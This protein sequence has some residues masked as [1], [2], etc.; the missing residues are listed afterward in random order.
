M[1][2]PAD[3]FDAFW[4]LPPPAALSLLKSTDGGLTQAEAARRLLAQRKTGRHRPAWIGV[5]RLFLRQFSSPLVL[6]L[7]FAVV[8]SSALGQYSDAALI[9]GILF[10]T[11][12]M[13][14]WQEYR[15]SRTVQKLQALVHTRTTV[16]RG[17]NM[18]NIRLEDVVPGD[19][20]L[21]KAGDVVPG[22]C[23]L[24]QGK[25]VHVNESA[26]T[27]ESFPAEKEPCVVPADAAMTDRKNTLFE[28]SSVVSGEATALVVRSGKDTEFGKIAT[29]MGQMDEASA[30]QIGIRHFG[31]LL[32]RMTFVLS[33]GILIF[34]LFFHKPVVESILFSI[35]LA[36]GLAPE[37][38]PAIL[39][40]TLSAGAMRMAK[41]KVIVKKLAAIQ[42]LGA[43]NILCSDKTGTLTVGSAQVHAMAD[44]SNQPSD[45]VRLYAYLNAVFETGFTNPLDEAIRQ[46]PGID[47]AGYVKADEV[48]YDFLRKRLSIVVENAAKHHLMLTK[49]AL[50]NV[51]D[52]CS[53]AEM[54][55]GTLTPIA[56]AKPGIL[57]TYEV[58][59]AQGLRTIGL[60]WKDVSGDP[61]I[62]KDDECEMIFLGFIFLEDPPK[63][64]TLEN[65]RDLNALGVRLKIITGDN[66]L[67]AAHL[68]AAIGLENTRLL[69]GPELAKMSDAALARQAQDVDLF[70][71]VEPQQ[72]ERVIRLLRS[73]GD[74]VGYLGDGI[75]DAGALKAAD[76]GISVDSGVDVAK[77]AADIV[78]LEK[79]LQ[80]LLNGI[81]DGRKTYINTLKYIFIT[82]SANFGNMFSLAGVSLLLPWLPLLPKQI[83]A[84]N[85]ISDVPALTIASDRVD[86]EQLKRPKHWDIGLIRRFMIVF[87]VQSSLFDYLTFGAL[88]F[89]FHAGEGVF[90]TGWFVESVLTEV[91]VLLIIR[92][93]RPALKSRPSRWLLGT[94]IGT[95]ILT[96]ALPYWPV[97]QWIGL[98]PL[99]LT[100][101]GFMI[102]IA[103]VYGVLVE[104]TKRRFF[105]KAQL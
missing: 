105:R 44:V 86:A 45:K 34:N 83:L 80:V 103:A 17:G 15:A 78:L 13:G 88:L 32:M 100:L 81:L 57:N 59:S 67:A 65:V 58:Q 54:P 79:D 20:A 73:H 38:L 7:V 6:L 30:F 99:P 8:L 10:L 71:E 98:Q 35:A 64:R 94:S 77:E 101:L 11:G 40:T 39:V 1:R 82:T 43:I 68:A 23:L 52:V 102:A 46:L 29:R 9:F 2:Q 85:F 12:A 4:Q 28:G 70:A 21:L 84:L 26:L 56:T 104:T 48:P 96:I 66:R 14:F 16:R 27:G 74:V 19:I 97:G 75:N 91:L 5:V 36:V 63:P 89:V 37:L 95:A 69:N 3:P 24:L 87:G 47:T 90:Q 55:D 72:K 93:T 41:D 60:A 76:V 51:L 50:T 31:Y 25:D 42:D 61:V 49:G 92:T 62:D 33:A 22:D 18:Q 53:H